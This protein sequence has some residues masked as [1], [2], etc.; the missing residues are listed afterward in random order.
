MSDNSFENL[1]EN[2]YQ[3]PLSHDPVKPTLPPGE[4][5]RHGCVTA[6]LVLNAISVVVSWISIAA[7]KGAG[8]QV[9]T[10]IE[11][12]PLYLIYAG[13]SGILMWVCVVGLWKFKRWAFYGW[14][15]LFVAGAI[16]NL[17]MGLAWSGI[18]GSAIGLA[19]LYGILQLGKPS[20][21][22]QLE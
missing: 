18:F 16:G 2:P 9:P 13:I 1:S 5:R 8:L 4:K 17:V 14:V 3:A 7:I 21:W 6:W 10:T 22:S 12:T 19:L 11:M 15:A 20:T